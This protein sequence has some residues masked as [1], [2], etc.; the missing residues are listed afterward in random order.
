M[1]DFFMNNNYSC[2]G[3]VLRVVDTSEDDEKDDETVYEVSYQGQRDKY[4]LTHRELVLDLGAGDLKF[5]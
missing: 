1:L 3:R 5:L 4:L 2:L